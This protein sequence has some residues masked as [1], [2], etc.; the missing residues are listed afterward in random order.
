MHTQHD[1]VRAFFALVRV[2]CNKFMS[3]WNTRVHDLCAMCMFKRNSNQI[4]ALLV[5]LNY[6][7]H[8]G[9]S[10]FY[11]EIMLTMWIM[12]FE[13]VSFISSLF[14]CYKNSISNEIRSDVSS[15][16]Q[17]G[18]SKYQINSNLCYTSLMLHTNYIIEY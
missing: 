2:T 7:M 11:L 16:I 10:L 8:F 14:Y 6:C 9:W 5:R 12:N 17:W 1:L 13:C 3:M 18:R 15:N 4:I